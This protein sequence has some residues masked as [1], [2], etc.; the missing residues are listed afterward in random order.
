M[1]VLTGPVSMTLD[2]GNGMR[3]SLTWVAV[4]T[5]IAAGC[6]TERG[7]DVRGPV[8]S[9]YNIARQ[10]AY[11]TRTQATLAACVITNQP[12]FADQRVYTNVSE[13]VTNRYLRAR[14]T[15]IPIGDAGWFYFVCHSWHSEWR[16]YTYCDVGDLSIGI[17]NA[18]N[19]YF[20]RTHVCGALSFRLPTSRGYTNMHDFILHNPDWHPLPADWAKFA[21]PPPEVDITSHIIGTWHATTIRSTAETSGIDVEFGD[22]GSAHVTIK[23]GAG[24]HSGG[25]SY[26]ILSASTLVLT[27]G[28]FGGQLTLNGADLTGTIEEPVRKVD[29]DAPMNV[30]MPVVYS[31]TNVYTCT[32]VKGK[33]GEAS[34]QAPEDTARKRADPQ[35]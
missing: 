18:R 32:F 9:R 2:A 33:T 14:D 15:W 16:N 25:T 35:H 24:S 12:A 21:P 5:A 28:F 30:P 20:C 22:Y 10:R 19:Y 17:D 1:R 23:A 11:I 29:C 13:G 3:T 8:N 6:T 4:A 34:N 31:H 7:L 26:E 27:N